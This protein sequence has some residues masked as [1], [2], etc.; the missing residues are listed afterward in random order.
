M[1]SPHEQIHHRDFMPMREQIPLRSAPTDANGDL[2]L[3]CSRCG[4][5]M[6]IPLADLLARH[7]PDA[8]LVNVLNAN[9]PEGCAQAPD[10]LGRRQCGLHYS[11]LRRISAPFATAAIGPARPAPL[12]ADKNPPH[13]EK[14]CP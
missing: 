4:R 10:D 8:G 7:G 6:A 9:L 5:R 11:D 12:S 1:H 13:S 14:T 2:R 3:G